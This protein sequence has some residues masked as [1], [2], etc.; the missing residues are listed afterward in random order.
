MMKNWLRIS[1][2]VMA[3]AALVG[4]VTGASAATANKVDKAF[5]SQMQLHHAMA[6]DM[7]RMALEQGEHAEIKSTSQTIIKSQKSEVVRLRKIAKRLGVP[8]T[9][10]HDHPRIMDELDTLGLNMETAGMAMGMEELDGADPFDRQFIDMMITHH[11][12]AILMA[13]AE[14]R[15]G[16]DPSLRKIA[17]LIVAAQ[18]EEIRRMNAWRTAWYGA[19]SPSGGVPKG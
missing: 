15:R 1:A 6:I 14:L 4:P 13:R 7:A 8:P 10:P 2:A 17:R 11:R 19:P 16:K 3:I 18:A 5:V 9:H 12:G